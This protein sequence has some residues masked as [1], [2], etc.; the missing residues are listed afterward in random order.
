MASNGKVVGGVVNLS[1]TQSL[2][3][4]GA[5]NG[6]SSIPLNTSYAVEKQRNSIKTQ[7]QALKKDGAL[8]QN[9]NAART[10]GTTLRSDN[11][12]EMNSSFHQLVAKNK[13]ESV[14]SSKNQ[15]IEQQADKI[16]QL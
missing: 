4:L 1:H 3:Q 7:K 2:A 9:E 13:Q 11:S 16:E 15:Q 12:Q 14:G 6:N 8:Q 10:Q 5:N